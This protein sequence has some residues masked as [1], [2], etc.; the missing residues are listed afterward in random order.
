M[1]SAVDLDRWLALVNA[2]LRWMPPEGVIHTVYVHPTMRVLQVYFGRAS[3]GRSASVQVCGFVL[4]EHLQALLDREA[5][6]QLGLA[7]PDLERAAAEFEAFVD[8]LAGGP[9]S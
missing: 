9:A 1:S 7:S 6:V 8:R 4:P 5:V 3:T 2:A